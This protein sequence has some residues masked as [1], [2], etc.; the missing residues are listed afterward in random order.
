MG[1]CQMYKL[2]NDEIITQTQS[3][4]AEVKEENDGFDDISITSQSER[5]DIYKLTGPASMILNTSF[6]AFKVSFAQEDSYSKMNISTDY[7]K[8][9]VITPKF[10]YSI[11]I[12]SHFSKE[13]ERIKSILLSKQL[14][15]TQKSFC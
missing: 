15:D 8:H 13:G 2:E 11:D 6:S 1:C 9:P 14:R 7:E 4:I 3:Y 10:G 12:Q 5:Y